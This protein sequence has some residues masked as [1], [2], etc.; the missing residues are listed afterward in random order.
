MLAF[1]EFDLLKSTS[2][3]TAMT[4]IMTIPIA[5][6]VEEKEF[7]DVEANVSDWKLA[8]KPFDEGFVCEAPRDEIVR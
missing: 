1:S 6:T 7:E 8:V 4:R 5:V 3:A 2:T